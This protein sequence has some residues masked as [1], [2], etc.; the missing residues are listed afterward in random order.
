MGH[1]VNELQEEFTAFSTAWIFSGNANSIMAHN[2]VVERS[3]D[4]WHG[5]CILVQG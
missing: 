5:W 3:P 4:F 2:S 1:T